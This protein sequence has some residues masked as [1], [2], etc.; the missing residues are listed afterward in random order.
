MRGV[1]S[2]GLAR[3]V[4]CSEN[5]KIWPAASEFQSGFSGLR[6]RV[7]AE[8]RAGFLH[9]QMAAHDDDAYNLTPALILETVAAAKGLSRKLRAEMS[10]TSRTFGEVLVPIS[11]LSWRSQS[12]V[13]R[14]LL[15]F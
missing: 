5:S 12:F 2:S 9:R 7:R 11:P 13:L 1:Q 3:T 10:V 15:N 14:S 4:L 8:S 6:W